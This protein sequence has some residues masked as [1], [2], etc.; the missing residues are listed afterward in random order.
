VL[1]AVLRERVMQRMGGNELLL[2]SLGLFTWTF[3]GV[4]VHMTFSK[5]FSN[6]AAERW[7]PGRRFRLGYFESLPIRWSTDADFQQL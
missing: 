6:V 5:M 1:E 7:G 3:V 4:S 2:Y